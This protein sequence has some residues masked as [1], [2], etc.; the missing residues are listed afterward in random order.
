MRIFFILFYANK[1]LISVLSFLLHISPAPMISVCVALHRRH[2]SNQTLPAN[3]LHCFLPFWIFA[4]GS[5]PGK[6]APLHF[7][8]ST[9]NFAQIGIQQI[10][11]QM[12][13]NGGNKVY[14]IF[15]FHIRFKHICSGRHCLCL[16]R[17]YIRFLHH[18]R[19]L[20]R[21]HPG[22]P[23]IISHPQ[24]E[25]NWALF[26]LWLRMRHAQLAHNDRN[27]AIENR[28]TQWA[29][30]SPRHSN[31]NNTTQVKWRT[32]FYKYFRIKR[33]AKIHNKW[34]R[35]IRVIMMVKPDGLRLLAAENGS[36]TSSA[37]TIHIHKRST[38]IEQ[39]NGKRQEYHSECSTLQNVCR[40]IAHC[41][42]A[43]NWM[44]DDGRAGWQ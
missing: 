33:Q 38:R 22:P 35:K 27:S 10:R 7:S 13:W 3:L 21:S 9:I 2:C 40:R 17:C 5:L 39:V 12:V 24:R 43:A 34:Q 19:H 41:A 36:C 11:R 25:N 37:G 1:T 30:P 15:S 29:T 26:I 16:H 23:I 32:T 28:R 14:E 18:I 31:K 6:F 20:N 8:F 42:C 44:R 4:F